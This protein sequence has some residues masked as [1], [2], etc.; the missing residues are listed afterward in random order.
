MLLRQFL[1]LIFVFLQGLSPLLHAHAGTVGHGGIHLPQT[2]GLACPDNPALHVHA[3][4]ESVAFTVDASL[5]ARDIHLL[6]GQAPTA[7]HRVVPVQQTT[8]CQAIQEPPLPPPL[9]A[10]HL[11]PHPCAPPQ[12]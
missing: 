9:L 10:A 6:P 4:D 7:F 8:L 1:V 11:I 2:N 3:M 12:A 5:Q